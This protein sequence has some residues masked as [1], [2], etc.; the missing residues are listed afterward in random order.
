[1]K[2]GI[3][4]LILAVAFCAGFF[5]AKM[6][7]L[8]QKEA[9]EEIAAV[10]SAATAV[11]FDYSEV[12]PYDGT[13][14]WYDVND[15]VPFLTE[16][17][18][19]FTGQ[20][21]NDLDKL[22]RTQVA[23]GC[24]GRE[25]MPEENE[26]RG[27]ISSIHPSGWAKAQSWERCHLIAWSLSAENAN[28]GNLITGT[29][30]LNYDSMRPLE[31]ETMQYIYNTG[32]HVLYMSEPIYK[33]DELV[34]RGVHMVARS[35]EDN[36]D[37]LSFNVYCFNVTPGAEIDYN[38]GIVTTGEQAKQDARLY[39]INKRSKVFHYPSCDGAKEMSKYNREEVTATRSELT[40]QGY[41][42]CGSCEP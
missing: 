6:D 2:K 26:D 5:G 31:E 19:A 23:F 10:E 8:G 13:H 41:T 37:G 1:M 34:A 40:S 15:D 35:V 4:F 28:P 30:Y 32:N 14:A 21:Y 38:T 3:K 11:A 12:P 7:D 17:D 18:M 25:T 27:D 36:G 33:G 20:F 29:H 22:G 9:T 42:P 16:E 39:V 24:L